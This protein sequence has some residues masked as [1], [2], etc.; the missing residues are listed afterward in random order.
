M[1]IRPVIG[2]MPDCPLLT[3]TNNHNIQ[4]HLLHCSYRNYIIVYSFLCRVLIVM[5]YSVRAD[6]LALSDLA[7]VVKLIST[8]VH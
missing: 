8:I 7:S 1:T 5:Q 6:G 4:V 3:Q 2:H